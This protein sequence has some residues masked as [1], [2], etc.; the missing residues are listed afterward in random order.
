[1][2]SGKIKLKCVFTYLVCQRGGQFP[3]SQHLLHMSEKC[4]ESHTPRPTENKNSTL[5]EFTTA[6]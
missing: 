4:K 6:V 2:Y 3:A 5:N 1:M